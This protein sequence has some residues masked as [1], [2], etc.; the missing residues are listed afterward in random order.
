[1]RDPFVV[2]YDDF[3]KSTERTLQWM[4]AR[5]PG[6]V[7]QG[8][9]NDRQARHNIEV[10]KAKLRLF[11]KFKKDPQLNLLKEFEKKKAS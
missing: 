5:Y 8:K 10:E 9:I 7:L 4:Q 2:T 6:M 3:I 11:K 1:M